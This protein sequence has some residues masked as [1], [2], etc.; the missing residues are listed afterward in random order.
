MRYLAAFLLLVSLCAP[1]ASLDIPQAKGYVNDSAGLLS[2]TSKL[3]LEQFLREFEKSDSTQIVV[4]TIPTLDGEVLEDYALRV[5][6]TWGV[7][8]KE[9]DNGALLLIAKAERKIR[10]EVGYGLEGR[11]TDLLAGRII[12]NEITPR[13]KQGDFD[14]GVIAGVVGM[15]EAVRGEYT[16][17]G[18]TTGQKK[19][20]HPFGFLLPL[21]FFGGP[22]L[23]R[24]GGRRRGF[25]RRRGFYVGGP[26]IGGGF[27]GGGI[28]GGGFSGGGGG[29]GGGGASGGW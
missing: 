4:L 22:L 20:K 28:G 5:L 27:G 25:H 23:A 7:G 6:E 21:L 29:G 10:I 2:Q 17:T 24:L 26:F 14:G 11:L 3:K 18:R 1:A 9:K 19:N 16:G 13:F 12:D 8:Q 15:A